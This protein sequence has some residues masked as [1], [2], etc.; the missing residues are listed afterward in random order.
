MITNLHIKNIGIIED[1]TIEFNNGFNVL[2]GE[3]GAGKSLIINSIDMISGGRFSKEMI[4]KNEKYAVVE[5]CL[6]VPDLINTFGEEYII[7]SREVHLNG[8]NLCKINGRL[9]TVNELKDFMKNIIDIHG[10]FDNQ[11][12]MDNKT[13]IQFLD[14][15]CDDKIES[16]LSEYKKMFD[17]YNNIKRE[18][19]NNYGDEIEKQRKLDLLNYQFNE[20]NEANLIIG[21]EEDLE[22]K[23]KIIINYEK[24]QEA[25]NFSTFKIENSILPD[26]DNILKPLEKLES[27]DN[28]YS[29]KVSSIKGIYYELQEYLNDLNEYKDELEFD[30][31]SSLKITQRL[32]LIYSLKRK[33]GTNIEEILNYKDKLKEEINEIENLEEYNNEL[34]N[35]LNNL[36]LN[37][38]EVAKKINDIREKYALI[39]EKCIN[40]ELK[41]LEM[42][43]AKFKVDITFNEELEFRSNGLNNVEFLIATNTGED[44]MPLTKIASGGEISRVMLAIKTVLTEVDKVNTIIFDEIDTGISGS[45]VKAV[46]DKIKM[47]SKSHQVLVVTHQAILAASADYNYKIK[48]SVRDGKTT[49]SI[50]KLKETQIVEEIAKISNGSITT[51]ALEHA[52]ELRKACII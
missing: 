24:I 6:Y 43:N 15:F 47:I 28:K 8:K 31:E 33:Y 16:Y 45:A 40:K 49:T 36:R 51:I 1:I 42:L 4:R 20:I 50:I 18:L 14:D 38:F 29:N 13:H 34:R 21:E 30:E 3:T 22:S 7:V 5:V 39:L 17:M 11:N 2:T 41:D 25:L 19:N 35:R 44:Y 26:F 37:M 23:K 10:Q 9:V 12:L 32:D 48:K 27:I 46:S 52:L